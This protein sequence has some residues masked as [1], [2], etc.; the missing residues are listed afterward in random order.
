MTEPRKPFTKA[1]GWKSLRRVFYVLGA[2]VLIFIIVSLAT[3]GG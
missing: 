2:Y 3:K 1:D